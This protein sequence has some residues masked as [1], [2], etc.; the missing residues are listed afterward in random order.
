MPSDGT[1]KSS[2]EMVAGVHYTHQKTS[3]PPIDVIDL[4]FEYQ[5]K[6]L[7]PVGS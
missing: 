3:F 1:G 6:A 5:G 7:V 2:F 4:Q